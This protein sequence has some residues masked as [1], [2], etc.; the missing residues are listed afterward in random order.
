MTSPVNSIPPSSQDLPPLH[1]GDIVTPELARRLAEDA[2]PPWM[3]AKWLTTAIGQ[4]G[5]L[6]MFAS[7]CWLQ[8]DVELLRDLVFALGLV[9]GAGVGGQ[10]WVDGIS[11]KG[12]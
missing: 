12:K 6:A 7:A 5:I 3:R 4:V 9:T 1:A 10:S 8:R 2:R 11:R